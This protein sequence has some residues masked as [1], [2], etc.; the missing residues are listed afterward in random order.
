MAV[1]ITEMHTGE[2]I[3]L[4]MQTAGTT[5]KVDLGLGK[6]RD[7]SWLLEIKELPSRI[8]FCL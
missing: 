3:Y 8:L 5:V 6:L 2:V 7:A 4:I 1:T